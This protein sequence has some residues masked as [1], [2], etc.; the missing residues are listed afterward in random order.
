M[1]WKVFLNNFNLYSLFT[2]RNDL[3]IIKKIAEQY[4][5]YSSAT[6]DFYQVS[7]IHHFLED[8]EKNKQF[9]GFCDLGIRWQAIEAEQMRSYFKLSAEDTG[10]LVAKVP[11]LSCSHGYLKKGDILMS[12]DGSPIAENGTVW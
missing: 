6:S 2:F 10:V 3:P 7:V 11:K 9:S 12:L 8:I 5:L 1:F 4:F